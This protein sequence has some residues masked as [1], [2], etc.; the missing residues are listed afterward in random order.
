MDLVWQIQQ[1]QLNAGY[2]ADSACLCCAHKR[3]TV[4]DNLNVHCPQLT[5]EDFQLP[6]LAPKLTV[7]GKEVSLG[8]GFHLV[9]GF[10][11]EPFAD[12]RIGLV[13]AFWALGIHLG[14]PLVR[15][16]LTACT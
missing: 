5:K 8:K 6:G 15:T 13:L 9:R 11:V 14:R 16:P 7:L 4:E 2:R 10:P 3:S 1:S 12:N